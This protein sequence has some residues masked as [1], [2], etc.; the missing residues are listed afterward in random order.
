MFF[1][2]TYADL[3]EFPWI[4]D[5]A[6]LP[7]RYYFNLDNFLNPPFPKIDL[8]LNFFSRY[9]IEDLIS[10]KAWNTIL[11]ITHAMI[12]S[13]LSMSIWKKY[14]VIWKRQIRNLVL[15]QNKLKRIL[16]FPHTY[17]SILLDYNS[18][19]FLFYYSTLENRIKHDIVIFNR[20]RDV[21]TIQLYNLVIF[22]W[23]KVVKFTKSLD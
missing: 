10:C 5:S 15:I 17:Q 23:E 14:T 12:L 18:E 13:T 16:N 2:S 9:F 3:I 8:I 6:P 20:H 4:L 19:K 7:I 11:Y 22:Y 1:F 21:L